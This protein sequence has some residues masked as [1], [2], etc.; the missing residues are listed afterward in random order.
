MCMAGVPVWARLSTK[1]MMYG[2]YVC[3]HT[4]KRD[5]QDGQLAIRSD[6]IEMIER[7]QF[8]RYSRFPPKYTLTRG[9]AYSH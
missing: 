6:Q 3:K 2:L 7:Q 1:V 4:R 5:R 9:S 8:S